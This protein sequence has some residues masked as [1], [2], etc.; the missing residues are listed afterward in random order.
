MQSKPLAFNS[1]TF[2]NNNEPIVMLYLT[3]KIVEYYFKRL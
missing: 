3:A 2:N 1:K